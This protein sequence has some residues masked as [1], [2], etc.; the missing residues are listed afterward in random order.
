MILTIDVGNSQI[1]CGVFNG[2]A[3]TVQFRPH[4]HRA[5]LLG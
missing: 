1:F 2:D 5:W 4:L 3:L